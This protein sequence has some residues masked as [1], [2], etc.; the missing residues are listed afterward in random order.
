MYNI[1]K[2]MRVRG[3]FSYVKF[4]AQDWVDF[5]KFVKLQHVQLIFENC[6]ELKVVFFD[7]FTTFS[8]K[9][10]TYQNFMKLSKNTWQFHEF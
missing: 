7:S 1:L 3:S 5:S 8:K 9:S 6:C 2:L 10:L 4:V